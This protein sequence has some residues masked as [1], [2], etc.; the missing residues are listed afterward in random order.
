MNASLLESTAAA[1]EPVEGQGD[2]GAEALEVFPD[3]GR[4]YEPVKRVMD[5]TLALAA[6][7]LFSPVWALVAIGVRITSP[8]PVFYKTWTVGRGGVPFLI[9]K[10]RTMVNDASESVHRRWAEDFVRNDRP[11]TVVK[12]RS[13]QAQPVYKVINDPRVTAFGRILRR[14]GLD[15]VPQFINVVRGE[16]SVVGPRSP[17]PFEFEHCGALARRRVEVLP[18][19][20]GLYQVTARSRATFSEIVSIDLDYIQ[21]RSLRLDLWIMLRTIPVM[22]TGEGGY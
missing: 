6:L 10:F 19:I 22:L 7:V 9:Y 3:P 1:P 18:G 2:T 15:E 12:D 11:F 8:G 20:T 14:T 17:R 4:F 5:V 13:G 21:R 16:M